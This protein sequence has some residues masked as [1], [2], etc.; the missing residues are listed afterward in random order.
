MDEKQCP[1]CAEMVKAQ[2]TICRFCQYDFKTGRPAVVEVKTKPKEPMS[3][4]SAIAILL[5]LIFILYQCASSDSTTSTSN[6]SAYDATATDY[7]PKTWSYFD[8]TD[9]VSGKPIRF[10]TLTSDNAVEFDFPYQGGATLDIVVRE[11]PRWGTNVY[12]QVSKGQIHCRYDGCAGSIR[13]G[14]K[15]ERLTLNEPED[16]S[17]EVVFAAYPDAIIRGLK[18]SDETVVELPFFQEGNRSFRFQTK[19]LTWPPK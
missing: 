10:A 5:F 16:N 9:D 18:R 11:H 6:Q 15:A 2:A 14:D 8:Q 13:F 19:G 17:N 3:Y 1:Q 12:F 4:A 7:L